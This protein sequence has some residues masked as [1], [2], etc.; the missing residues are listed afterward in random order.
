MSELHLRPHFLTTVS[1]WTP[2]SPFHFEPLL[3]P[4]ASLWT[5]FYPSSRAQVHSR[6]RKRDHDNGGGCEGGVAR[7]TGVGGEEKRVSKVK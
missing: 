1:P 7:G 5:P 3:F 4:F 6:Y 2:F